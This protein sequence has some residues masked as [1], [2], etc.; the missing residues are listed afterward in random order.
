MPSKRISRK[1]APQPSH[2]RGRRESRPNVFI[3][4]E[5]ADGNEA[6]SV[7]APAVGGRADGSV[8]A[9]IVAVRPAGRVRVGTAR[10]DIFT[11]TLDR[12]LKQLVILTTLSVVAVI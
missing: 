3:Q 8:G 4:P 10:A 11:R 2:G 9:D 7:I 5:K 12:E 6:Q 1:F